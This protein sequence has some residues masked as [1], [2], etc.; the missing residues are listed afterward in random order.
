MIYKK[1]NWDK[2]WARKFAYGYLKDWAADIFVN[3][4]GLLKY[5]E[6]PQILSAGCGRGLIDYWLINVFGYEIVLL[7][8]SFKCIKNLK[9]AFGKVKK[10]KFDLCYASILAIPYPD[11]RFD[12]V[13]NSGVLEHFHKEDYKKAIKEVV[14]I[15]QKYILIVV[16]Y[17]KSKPYM[18]AKK[19]LEENG[20]WVWGYEDPKVSLKEDLE[21]CSVEILKEIMIGSAQTNRNYIDMIPSDKRE[22]ILKELTPDDFETFPHLMV[23][24]QKK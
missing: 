13:W 15:S 23:I 17:A 21:A 8:N 19:W 12:L 16:P 10:D 2:I 1:A 18:V 20:L 24:G 6:N 5:I 14:R 4:H 3:I 22:Q 7:D 9:K 11:N